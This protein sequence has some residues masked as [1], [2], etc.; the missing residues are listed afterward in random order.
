MKR[1]RL[2][3]EAA[4]PFSTRTIAAPM[5]GASD[6]PF[7]LLVR[8]HGAAVAY[9]EMLF[10]CRFCADA[11]Y[12]SRKLQTTPEDRPLVV[13]F[14]ATDPGTLA[15][16]ARLVA[17]SCDAIDLNLGCPLPAAQT[18]GFG[19]SLLRR[20]SW[21]RVAAL[22]RA[23]AA[24]VALPVFAKI[25]LLDTAA[26]TIELCELLRSS[27]AALVAVHGRV[28]PPPHLHR[29]HR[30]CPA[31]LSAIRDV[32]RALAPFPIVTN[33]NTD[34]SADVRAN[35][36]LTGAA[37]LMSAEALL[38]DPLLF[39]RPEAWARHGKGAELRSDAEATGTRVDDAVAVSAWRGALGRV[40][41]EY[42]E[43]AAA[44]P[45]GASVIRSHL[46][47]MLGKSGKAHRM[48]FEHT[49]PYSAEQLRMALAS[50]ETVSDFE[51][52]VRA[53]LDVDA[54]SEPIATLVPHEPAPH[55]HQ[56]T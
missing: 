39:S 34:S 38:R 14:C 56:A 20:E 49:G 23:L 51:Q 50:A 52:L 45:P 53:V 5:V 43:L 19:A 31:D 13:Q 54:D 3:G 42:L 29:S 40:A 24:A 37:G 44:Y 46:M 7:R 12:R 27:G 8:R 21:P 30:R 18:K 4:L 16:A 28:V 48:T 9:T 26:E 25:R 47:W 2:E 22:V 10:A 15:A 17:P 6:L 32:V 1:A 55:A 33:G 36:E 11:E 35:L 41:L